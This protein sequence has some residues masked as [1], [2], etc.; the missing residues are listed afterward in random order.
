MTYLSKRPISVTDKDTQRHDNS[1]APLQNVCGIIFI[2][3]SHLK[4][5]L[6]MRV[7]VCVLLLDE[8]DTKGQLLV[9]LGS[10]P[11]EKA[12]DISQCDWPRSGIELLR[13]RAA[14]WELQ[15]RLKSFQLG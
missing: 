14:S 2:D 15:T 4:T 6:S 3:S 8:E 5:A 10:E 7:C 13:D 11:G 9:S 12:L 1:Q